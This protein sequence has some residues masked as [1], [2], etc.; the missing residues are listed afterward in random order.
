M[1]TRVRWVAR[2]GLVL[3]LAAALDP[4]AAGHGGQFV[5]PPPATPGNAAPPGTPRANTPTH[6]TPGVGGPVVTP[7]GGL[8]AARPGREAPPPGRVHAELRPLLAALVGP[9]PARPAARPARRPVAGRAHPRGRGRRPRTAPAGRPSATAS[10]RSASCRSC[11][12]CSTRGAARTTTSAP[13]RRSRSASSLGTARR[14]PCS[15]AGSSTSSAPELVRE[16]AALALGLLRR[17]DPARQLGANELDPLRAKLL[18]LWDRQ[19]DGE[20]VEAPGRARQFAMFALGL[21]G[22]QPW[23]QDPQSKDGRLMSQLIW[24][25]YTR[26][27]YQDASFRIAL[28]TGARHA[29]VDRGARRRA[30]RGRG[31]RARREGGGATRRGARAG[32]RAH[33]GRAPRRPDR[34]LPPDPPFEREARRAEPAARCA[35]PRCSRSPIASTASTR[36]SG[37]S[38]PGCSSARSHPSRSCS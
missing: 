12:R 18:M 7:G 14:S 30:A 5:P 33:R 35:S 38:S 25:R 16:S 28:L 21:L 22:D 29:A 32:P 37:C 13:P 3:L 9:R 1:E 6:V 20:R 2:I 23:H 26:G 17:T 19:V 36:R 4:S 31:A 24:Q 34:D 8:H 10:S 15:S 11:S 27:R